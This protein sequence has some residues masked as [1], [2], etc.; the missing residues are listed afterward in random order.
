MRVPNGTPYGSL[1]LEIEL[2]GT[3]LNKGVKKWDG[4][5]EV[6]CFQV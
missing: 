1:Y 2:Q 4:E 5:K 3:P 6:T